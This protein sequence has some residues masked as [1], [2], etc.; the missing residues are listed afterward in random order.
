M[1]ALRKILESISTRGPT[2]G[3]ISAAGTKHINLT[4]GPQSGRSNAR[5]Q[6]GRNS[7]GEIGR[8]LYWRTSGMAPRRLEA[9]MA[10]KY[11][12]RQER[13]FLYRSCPT[14]CNPMPAV[15]PAA[16][17]AAPQH[18]SNELGAALRHTRVTCTA[19]GAV[20]RKTVKIL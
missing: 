9:C 16:G 14:V 11:R 4:Y 7:I 19:S 10:L 8:L 1:L 13:R 12:N 6:P 18:C 17:A 2:G 5:R 15:A 3:F 20:M